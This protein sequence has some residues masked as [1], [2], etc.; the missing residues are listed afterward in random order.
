MHPIALVAVVILVWA[1]A[2]VALALGFGAVTRM[3]HRRRPRVD[4]RREARTRAANAIERVVT[5][6]TGGI[7]TIRSLSVA[8]GA[9][10]VIRR[11]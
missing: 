9:I 10:P 7:P 4:L 2:S 11:D 8:T 5:L 6:A 1:G 3:A